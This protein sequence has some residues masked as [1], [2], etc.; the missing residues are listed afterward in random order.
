MKF[1]E[2][3]NKTFS[4]TRF[5]RGQPLGRVVKSPRSTAVAQGLDP[6]RGHCSSGHVEAAF[7]MPQ[8]EGPTTKI[9]NYV[10]R[11]LGR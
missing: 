7:H 8:L 6:G 1:N 3:K 10:R 2:G 11:G 9:Y 5:S 4:K